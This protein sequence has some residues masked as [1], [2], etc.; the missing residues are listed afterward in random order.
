M[1]KDFDELFEDENDEYTYH[2]DY[3][4]LS[5]NWEGSVSVPNGDGEYTFNPD[6]DFQDLRN[7]ATRD[8]Q[9]TYTTT[10]QVDDPS[11]EP[12]TVTIRVT[13]KNDAPETSDTP[14]TNST[15]END[16]ILD[17]QVPTATDI[18]TSNGDGLQRIASHL[19]CS[20]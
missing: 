17:G 5:D 3:E 2:I 11:I 20:V 7:G 9:F 19:M 1:T 18:D 15:D 14:V 13:G 8:I 4:N 6:N 16:D 12:A 10:N